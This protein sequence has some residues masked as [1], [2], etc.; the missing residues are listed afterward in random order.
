MRTANPGG[1]QFVYMHLSGITV[2][3]GDSLSVGDVIGY[4]GDTGNAVGTNHLHFEFVRIPF[5]FF[6][7][8]P[9]FS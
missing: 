2:E 5:Y 6:H 4:V 8:H 1:E 7:F 9:N 3:E